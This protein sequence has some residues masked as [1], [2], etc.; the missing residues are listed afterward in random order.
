M[1]DMTYDPEADAIYIR[2]GKGKFDRTEEAG[3]F[4]YDVDADGR[5]LGIEILF[6]S[7]TLA[8]GNWQKAPLS[9]DR[10]ADAAE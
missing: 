2:I 6:V 7:Q 1:T 8:P 4:I 3:P 5:I 10:S 9:R